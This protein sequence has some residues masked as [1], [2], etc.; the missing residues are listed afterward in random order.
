[1][2]SEL[3]LSNHRTI[4]VCPNASQLRKPIN[5]AHLENGTFKQ[6]VSYHEKDLELIGLET[7]GE[8][9]ITTVAQQATQQNLENRKPTGHHCKKPGRFQNQY[10]QLKRQKDQ[11]Q[12]NTNS[13]GNNNNNNNNNCGETNSKTLT[14][15]IRFPKIPTQIIHITEMTENLHLSTHLVGLA[16]KLTTPQTKT[17]LEQTQLVDRFPETDSWKDKI[18]WDKQLFKTMQMWMYQLQL[19]H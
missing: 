11:A 13:A 8:L 7:P 5:Q 4:H 18:R 17:T 9:Q 2:H 19:K 6:I 12:N 16:V 15:T 1:M 14:P 3:P 10:R